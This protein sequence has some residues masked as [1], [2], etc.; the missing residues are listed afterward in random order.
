MAVTPVYLRRGDERGICRIRDR[1]AIEGLS[2]GRN[3]IRT[4]RRRER[5]CVENAAHGLLHDRNPRYRL[6]AVTQE[7]VTFVMLF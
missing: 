1:R 6:S 2:I 5:M 4:S 3:I 7:L